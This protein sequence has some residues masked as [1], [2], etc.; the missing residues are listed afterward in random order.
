MRVFH[1]LGGGVGALILTAGAAFA[2]S[3]QQPVPA[4]PGNA[5]G[6]SA[7]G[8]EGTTVMERARPDYDRPGVR[9]GSFIAKPTI[10][11]NETY[12]SNI[13]ATP[14]ATSDFYTS[15]D[16]G[17]SIQSDWGRHALAF[18]ASGDFK[19]YSAHSSENTNNGSADVSGRYDISTG[20]YL[21]GDMGY[22]LN[23]E[24]RSSPSR[25]SG[26]PVVGN[27]K[28]PVQ[29]STTGGY[30]G[31]VR[32]EGRVGLNVDGTV[33][34]YSYV[35]NSDILGGIVT[36]TDRSRI[37][38]VGAV[39]AS[40]ELIPQLPYNVFI[41]GL[42]NT[43]RYNAV[44][45]TEASID[46]LGRTARRNSTGWEVDVGGQVQ[47]TRLITAEIYAGWLD[48]EYDSALYKS[49]SAPAFGGNLLWSI[50]SLT[51]IKASVSQSVAETDLTGA[52]SSTEDNLSLTVEHELLANV[53]LAG[54][55]GYVHDSYNGVSR[56]DDTY[57]VDGGVRYLINR[58]W[59]ATGDLS[60]SS[61]SSSTSGQNYDRFIATVGIEAGF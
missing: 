16:P 2:Q 54:S 25:D 28:S 36:E 38:Y 59:R 21:V 8:P 56:T 18:N 47:I 5:L 33:T 13:F 61:R 4:F 46:P 27:P 23:H 30:V 10:G 39:K 22:A 31:Y 3:F 24:D 26:G 43:R 32:Q 6:P 20:S 35:N 57:G 52:S 40:Y 42:G 14:S 11:V 29:Y 44:D 45:S 12:D 48:Q 7:V 53:I 51:S 49:V 41:R 37:E 60:Y 50:T 19:W 55:A 58:M 34:S 15:L 17:I 1:V 9:M